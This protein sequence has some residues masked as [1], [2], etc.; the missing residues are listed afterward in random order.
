MN[1]RAVVPLSPVALQNQNGPSGQPQPSPMRSGQVTAAV[2]SSGGASTSPSRRTP[3]QK[4]RNS[5]DNVAAVLGSSTGS[6]SLSG[7]FGSPLNRTTRPA[8]HGTAPAPRSVSTPATLSRQSST[9]VPP[10]GVRPV[11]IAPQAPPQSGPQT[12]NTPLSSSQAPI[13]VT[14]ECR[15]ISSSG[16]TSTKP[17]NLVVG[18]GCVQGYRPTMEDEHFALLNATQV[19]GQSVSMFG[20]LDGHCGRKVA[21]LGAKFVPECFLSHPAVG[22]NNALALVEAIIQAD[23]NVFQTIG[24]T[25]G[26]STLICAV[27]HGRM[28]FVG[29]LGDARAV[30]CDGNTT[31][32]MSEDHKPTDAKENARVVRCGGTVQFGRVCAC[33]AVSRALGDFEFKFSGN[34]FVSNKE[35]MVSNVADVKQLNITDAT[36]FLLLACDGLWDVLS[37]EEATHFVLEYLKR[38]DLRD[39]QKA[40]DLC[41]H[42]LCEHAVEKGSMD[43]VSVMIMFF[44]DIATVITNNVPPSTP[45]ASAS[46]PMKGQVADVSTP[47]RRTQPMIGRR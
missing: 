30:V 33:L 16:K 27:I 6:T 3:A 24:K 38:A 42:R 12:P 25:D 5:S 46:S 20:I 15:V 26:G 32:A 39:P 21:D 19:D 17:L 44:H 23:R 34:R 29:C 31:I 11:G 45:G 41:S 8:A 36:K 9:F 14:Y 1:R 47:P 18:S 10:S 28:L 43:N 4:Y 2:G 7:N 22:Q 37:N 13:S 40:L 35:L